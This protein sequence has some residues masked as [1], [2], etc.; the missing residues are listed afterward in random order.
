MKKGQ[1]IMQPQGAVAIDSPPATGH[2]LGTGESVPVTG[3]CDGN[4]TCLWYK[5]LDPSEDCATYN[6]NPFEAGATQIY[7]DSA[8]N[9]SAGSVGPGMGGYGDRCVVIWSIDNASSAISMIVRNFSFLDP[10]SPACSGSASGTGWTMGSGWDFAASDRP[11]WE[12]VIKETAPRAYRVYLPGEDLELPEPL[13]SLA[14]SDGGVVLDFAA[15]RSSPR[16]A[17]W[18]TTRKNAAWSL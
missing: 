6:K 12:P 11:S 1:R 18:R 5:L 13:A 7:P 10:T 16:R 8:G 17:V 4:T 14:N 2:C 3:T 9:W 15:S